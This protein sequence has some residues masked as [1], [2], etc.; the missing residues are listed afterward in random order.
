MGSNQFQAITAVTS[1]R[2]LATRVTQ[3]E[4]WSRNLLGRPGKCLTAISARIKAEPMTGRNVAQT[5]TLSGR[6]MK[7]VS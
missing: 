2:K 3:R 6:I 4:D 5:S 7:P 1:M